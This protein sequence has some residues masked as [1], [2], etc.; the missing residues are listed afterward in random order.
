MYLVSERAPTA[1]ASTR[2]HIESQ[3]QAE[4]A[5]DKEYGLLPLDETTDP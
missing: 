1:R 3:E 4:G 2:F 5:D